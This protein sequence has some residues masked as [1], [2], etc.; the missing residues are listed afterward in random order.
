[1]FSMFGK[2]EAKTDSLNIFTEDDIREILGSFTLDPGGKTS[3][4]EGLI[5]STSKVNIIRK[6]ELIDAVKAQLDNGI[7]IN[8][9]KESSHINQCRSRFIVHKIHCR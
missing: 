2:S 7:S 4:S 3:G 9:L 6:E 5:L 8:K 1:M